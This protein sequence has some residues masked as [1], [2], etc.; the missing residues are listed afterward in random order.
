[1]IVSAESQRER[2]A[3][4][5]GQDALERQVVEKARR[6]GCTCEA[7]VILANRLRGAHAGHE[8]TCWLAVVHHER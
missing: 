1:M 5:M 6:S 7:K 4:Q 2:Y 3:A 8:F